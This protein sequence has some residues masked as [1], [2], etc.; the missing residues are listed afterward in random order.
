MQYEQVK[1]NKCV[2]LPDSGVGVLDCDSQFTI[3]SPP[4]INGPELW[5]STSVCSS[6]YLLTRAH[7]ARCSPLIPL[8]LASYLFAPAW[9]RTHSP[10]CALHIPVSHDWRRAC[11]FFFLAHQA[12]WASVVWKSI[13]TTDPQSPTTKSICSNSHFGAAALSA[14]MML[15]CCSISLDFIIIVMSFGQPNYE[16]S[17][18]FM[19]HLS[20]CI[21]TCHFLLGNAPIRLKIMMKSRDILSPDIGPGIRTQD[22]V[23]TSGTTTSYANLIQFPWRNW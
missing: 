13:S 18:H 7:C 17:V 20:L 11:L 15:L 1:Y 21:C 22:S 19:R 3:L 2:R 10:D 23:V 6:F 8:W 4:S 9:G 12:F 5:R 16:S 14:P